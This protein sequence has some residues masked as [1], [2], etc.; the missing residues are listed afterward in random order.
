MFRWID[1]FVAKTTERIL[2]KFRKDVEKEEHIGSFMFFL[3]H[4]DGVAGV[5]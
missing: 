4:A 2:L 5:S 1:G 3:L